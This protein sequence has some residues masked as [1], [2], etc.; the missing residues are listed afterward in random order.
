MLT[1]TVYAILPPPEDEGK[2]QRLVDART[3]ALEADDPDNPVVDE[4]EMY[5]EEVG[6]PSPDGD[7]HVAI[8]AVEVRQ[9]SRRAAENH[10]VRMVDIPAGTVALMLSNSW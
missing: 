6:W 5:F 2:W 8:D 10:I 3:A 1:T 4:A 7:R 9:D